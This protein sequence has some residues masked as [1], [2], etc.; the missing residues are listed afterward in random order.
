[1]SSFQTIHG[2]HRAAQAIP[3]RVGVGFKTQ[4]A[5]AIL[6]T[7]PDL[8]WLE[9]HPENYMVPGGPRPA[10]LEAVRDHYPLSLHGVALSL[11]GAERLDPEH[12]V[13]LRVLI[14]RYEPG[15]VSEHVA[16]SVQDGVYFAD[17]L[18]L[19]L[20]AET[21]DYLCRNIDEA[22]DFLGRQILIENPANYMTVPGSELPEPEFLVT[23]ARRTG[24]GLLV[25][26]NNIH[27][28]ARNIGLD[29]DAY[30]DGLPADLIGE[31]HVAGHAEDQADEGLLI[32]SHGSEVAT[33]VW[34][35]LERLITRCG[36][37]PLLVEWDTDVPS[38]PVLHGEVRKA[39]GTLS[40][41]DRPAEAAA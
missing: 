36:P 14:D 31:I 25:D 12:L 24:C 39:Q 27:V 13:A 37:K 35:L 6:N 32:D 3:D 17:L 30:V 7:Q 23:A 5:E 29:A 9:V 28:S 8:G 4:H 10:L 18:P 26:V 33:D 22:Q 11:G 19:P 20:N 15:L 34:R 40:R 2:H 16:W 1:M 38:W 21:L 41:F